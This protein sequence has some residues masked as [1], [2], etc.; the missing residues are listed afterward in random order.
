MKKLILGAAAAF[1]VVAAGALPSFMFGDAA[2]ATA[3]AP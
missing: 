2:S 1:A 3:T